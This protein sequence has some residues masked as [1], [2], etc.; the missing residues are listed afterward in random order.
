MIKTTQI[1]YKYPDGASFTF[2]EV[3]CA[4]EEILLI[5][6]NSGVGKSTL[7]HLLCGLMKPNQGDIYIG[8]TN[9]AQL[10]GSQLDKFR[11][12]NIGIVF[13]KNHF[14]E[15]LDCMENLLLAQE[16]AGLNRDKSK[17]ENLLNRLNI[18]QHK[19]SKIKNLS[20]GEKQRLSIARALINDPKVIFADEPTASLDD[21]NCETVLQLLKE[22]AT[23]AQAALIIVTH[24][25]RLKN[26]IDNQINLSV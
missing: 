4:Q 22:Q 17:C 9:I 19:N 18:G 20:E 7:L 10:N 26:H 6:G 3:H 23:Q 1:D 12:K 13:Q 15:S 2:P 5:I 16:L 11:G 24:D 8:D 25:S 21:N 14:I